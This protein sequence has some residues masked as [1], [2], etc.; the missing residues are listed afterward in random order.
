[1]KIK[2]TDAAATEL[3]H[4]A[5]ELCYLAAISRPINLFTSSSLLEHVFLASHDEEERNN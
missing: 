3:R 2:F 5:G 4:L 1:M